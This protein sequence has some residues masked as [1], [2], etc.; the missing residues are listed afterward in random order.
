[1]ADLQNQVFLEI[2]GG[3]A[4]L[5]LGSLEERAVIL[6]MERMKS[7]RRALVDLRSNTSVTALLIVGGSPAMF[8]A[9]A[10]LDAIR[11]VVD[12]KVGEALAQEGQEIFDVLAALPFKKIAAISG[13]CVGGGC[14]LVLA[15]DGRVLLDHPSTRIGLP[16]VKLGILPGF[17]GTQRLPRLIG[18]PRAL[19]VILKGKVL[20]APEALRIGLADQVISTNELGEGGDEHALFERFEERAAEIAL[21]KRPLKPGKPLTVGEKFLTHTLVGRAL[22]RSKSEAAIAKETR[23]RLPAP[24]KA[25]ESALF[26]LQNGMARGLEKERALLAEL[27]VSPESKSLV[28]LF[29]VS[30]DAQKL[31]RTLKEKFKEIDVAVVGGGTMGAG[32][33][34]TC[35]GSGIPTT[36]VEPVEEVRRRA[37]DHI[38]GSLEKKR[39]LSPEKRR[40]LEGKLRIVAGAD[41]IPVSNVIIEAI[42]E[43]VKAKQE[44][45][46][47]LESKVAAG[48]VLSTNTSSL[49]LDVLGEKLVDRSRFVGLHFFNPAER[50]P[51]IEVI[52][53]KTTSDQAVL[54][55]AAFASRIGKYPIVVEDVPGFLVNRIL[56]PYLVEASYLLGEGYSIAEIDKGAEEFGMPMGPLRLLDEIG[57]DVAAKVAEVMEK[58]YGQRMRGNA[59]AA[60]LT[61][62]GYFGRK[63]GR[64]FYKYGEKSPVPDAGIRIELGLDVGEKRPGF[65]VADRLIL[66]LV[67][68]AIRCLDDG[69]A[70]LPGAEAAGQIDLGTVMGIGFPAF[71]GGAIWYANSVGSKSLM[72]KL[73]AMQQVLGPRFEAAEGVRSRADKD[74]GFFIARSTVH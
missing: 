66:A 21:G 73:Q 4:T 30:E 31:G 11:D 58:A 65:T 7:L 14:E 29:K 34:A 47:L 2:D 70:G 9:G 35:L 27:I 38:L 25:L 69:V 43:D 23:G 60:A 33:G 26:G 61:K 52:R 8:C 67:N 62:K 45:Y 50:M 63:S 1:M 49:Q 3:L 44:L 40:E 53:A 71:R 54:A 19:D 20:T 17:G 22:V 72:Q 32:I 55:A 56:T 48:G 64:G 12:R 57:L 68:E 41:S 39:S 5:R 28:H 18:L 13:P 16:E 10:D 15:C 51:L 37:R 42:I 59:F 74:Q 46:Q 36:I 6:S 24:V